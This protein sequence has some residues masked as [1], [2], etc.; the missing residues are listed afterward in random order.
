MI[1]IKNLFYLF[2]ALIICLITAPYALSQVTIT[3]ELE[4]M[5]DDN[6]YLENGR[7][8]NLQVPE[9]SSL[10]KS[11]KE[12]I[13]GKKNNDF[14]FNPSIS[15]AG[16][17]TENENIETSFD[18]SIATLIFSKNSDNSKILLDSYLALSST[19]N[20]LQK[21]WFFTL[22][23]KLD[24]QSNNI[25]IASN[26][27]A[28]QNESHTA[29]FTFGIENLELSN[30]FSLFS[31]YNLVRYDFLKGFAFKNEKDRPLKDE[32]GADYFKNSIYTELRHQTTEKLLTA[33]SL[34]LGYTD[35]TAKKR[36]NTSS[37]EN[38]EIYNG[39]N[40]FD[41]YNYNPKLIATYA[42]NQLTSLSTYIGADGDYTPEAKKNKNQISLSYG[43]IISY[44]P[45][46]DTSIELEI[47]QSSSTDIDGERIITRT[48]RIDA[49]YDFN[50]YT[51]LTLGARFLE[52]D[53]GDSLSKSTTR[54]ELNSAINI[55]LA[56]SIALSFGYSFIDQ[57]AKD[58]DTLTTSYF[59]DSY[60]VNR[61]FIG[62][63]G[64]IIGLNN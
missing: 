25:G 62:I 60:T 40:D 47:K 55:A 27:P 5:Y 23:S 31:H 58:S 3:L 44:I 54:Y 21:P 53:N 41:R 64:G 63:S 30:N 59:N 38:N 50:Y 45:E 28:R 36:N 24:S 49:N 35:F 10:S 8:I 14:I 29:S 46:E 17:F 1:H 11:Q 22:S 12:A 57:D 4:G 9:N 48:A 39:S 37:E 18:A 6:I 43:G 52:F 34:D 51:Y 7:E 26:S 33:L 61:I 16:S 32:E 56:E 42:I 13:D 2:Y 19:E 20:L 15:L